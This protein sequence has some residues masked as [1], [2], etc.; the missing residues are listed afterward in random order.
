MQFTL[1]NS[2]ANGSN[3]LLKMRFIPETNQGKF[4]KKKSL[5]HDEVVQK[6]FFANS[7]DQSVKYQNGI[8]GQLQSSS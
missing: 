2:S 8:M 4:V 5:I 3:I 7:F 6:G 1:A